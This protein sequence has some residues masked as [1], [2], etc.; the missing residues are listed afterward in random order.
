MRAVIET[1]KKKKA[2]P[3]DRLLCYK[4]KHLGSVGFSLLIII[5][6]IF[7]PVTSDK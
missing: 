7:F 6:I 2:S 5:I 4:T 3:S 1:K